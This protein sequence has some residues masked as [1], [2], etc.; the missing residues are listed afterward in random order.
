MAFVDDTD[1]LQ[2]AKYPGDTETEVLKYAQGN[3]D[4]WEGAIRATGGALDPLKTHWFLI[5]FTWEKGQWKYKQMDPSQTLH[6]RNSEGR[7]VNIKQ[8]PVS[9]GM[10]TLGVTLA[11]DGNKKDIIQAL[12]EKATKWADLVQSGHLLREEAWRAL[13]S[14]IMKGLEYP[15]LATTLTEEETDIIFSP[16]PTGSTA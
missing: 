15:L 13:N 16:H 14:T 2:K 4:H 11:P 9:K 8:L 5:D 10:K 7:R 1:T 3:V 6:M 12:L